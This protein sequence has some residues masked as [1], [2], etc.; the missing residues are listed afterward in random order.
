MYYVTATTKELI[1]FPLCR[2]VY[3][4]IWKILDLPLKQHQCFE[5]NYNPRILIQIYF[6]FLEQ[7]YFI[8]I[9]YF[10]L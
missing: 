4:C 6:S 5:K 2:Y 10:L 8:I 7:M 1:H 3:V 9:N